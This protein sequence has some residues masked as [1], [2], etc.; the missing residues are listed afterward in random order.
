MNNNLHIP[1]LLSSFETCSINRAEVSVKRKILRNLEWLLNTRS[2]IY[3]EDLSDYPHVKDSVMAYGVKEYMNKGD[4][5]K[6]IE[7]LAN[8]I[9]AAVLKYE[10]RIERKTLD[11][12]ALNQNE[13]YEY[14]KYNRI[15]FL[16]QGFLQTVNKSEKLLIQ[17][18]IDLET[19]RCSITEKS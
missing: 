9:K 13:N 4:S 11:V 7:N 19:G 16:I 3:K 1:D 15:V 12:E 2:T 6:S 14:I 5:D 10:P 18:E 8:E 17:T